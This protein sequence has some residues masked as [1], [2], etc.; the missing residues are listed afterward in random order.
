MIRRFIFLL[1]VLGNFTVMPISS[2]GNITTT[3]DYATMRKQAARNKVE[4][5]YKDALVVF[6]ALIAS[7]KDDLAADDY[8]NAI[9]CY[10]NLNLQN[11]TDAFTEDII[12]IYS[13]NTALLIA[14]AEYYYQ[15]PHYGYI[16]SGKFRRGYHRGGG[17]YV[18]SLERDRVR[19][20]QL[21]E[22]A[23]S[24]AA[25]SGEKLSLDFYNLF[26][27]VILLQHNY[28][29]AWR[30]QY[31]TDTSALPD[32]S[33]GYNSGYN[34]NRAP[35]DENGNPVFYHIPKSY[36]AAANDGE[37]WR[38]MMDEAITAYPVSKN[39]IMQNYADFLYNQFGVQTMQEYSWFFARDFIEPPSPGNDLS[40]NV[41][42]ATYALHTLKDDETMAKLASGIKRFPLPDDCNYLKIYKELNVH[43]QLAQIYENR[44]QYNK[45]VNEWKKD[46]NNDRIKQITG[47]WGRFEST[48]TFAAGKN[49]VLQFRFRNGDEV[50]LT[51][52]KILIKPLLADIKEYIKSNPRKPEWYKLQI[53]NI[54]YRLV[55]KN[56]KKYLGDTV[57]EWKEKLRPADMHFDKRIDIKT[58]LKNAGAY[59][60]TARMKDGNIS[61]IVLW[62]NDTIIIRKNLDDQAYFYVADALTGRP[63]QNI[64][65]DFF[66]YKRNYVSGKFRDYNFETKEFELDT[67]NNGQC[68]VSSLK[69]NRSLQWLITAQNQQGRLAYMGFSGIWYQR[70]REQEYNRTKAFMIT[71]R[72]VYRP[73][74]IV[75]FK[76]WIRHTRYNQPDTSDFANKE[77]GIIITNP[78]GDKVFNKTFTTDK[79]G[80]LN[81]EFTLPE[82]AVLGIYRVAI[83]YQG[84]SLN[85]GSFRVEEYKKP[86][87]EVKI[88]APDKPVMLGDKIAATVRAKYYFGAPVV[89][90]KVKYKVLRYSYNKNW[91]PIDEWDWLYGVGYWW[92][93][94]DYN[95]YP[96]WRKWGCMPPR[97]WWLPVPHT[98]P[99]VIADSTLKLDKDGEG[100]ITI[101][102]A[103]TK[104]MHG[105]TDHRYEI[106]VEVT[107]ESRRT[108]VGKGNV[109]VARKPFKV[110]VWLDRGY[111]NVGDTIH[112]S[113]FAQ[114]LDNKPVKGHGVL[115]LYKIKY[116]KD[117]TPR[118]STVQQWQL[119]TD[120]QG[121]AKVQ[122]NAMIAGQYRFSY[123]LTDNNHHTIEGG[124]IFC[125]RGQG[126]SGKDFHF[127]NLEITQDHRTYKPGDKANIMIST[128]QKNSTVLLF[129]RPENGVY[130][131]PDIMHIKGK[132]ST[133]AI[134]ITGKDMPNI[135][136]EALTISN[137]KVYTAVREISVPPEKRVLNVQVLSPKK[138]YKP[139]EKA[140][141]TLR[142]TDIFGNPFVGSAVLTVYD[143][144]LEYISGGS[145]VGNIKEFFWKW[146][147]THTPVT[148]TSNNKQSYNLVLPKKQPMNNLGVFGYLIADQFDKEDSAASISSVKRKKGMLRAMGGAA[149]RME[150][151]VAD[152]VSPVMM[153]GIANKKEQPDNKLQ[154]EPESSTTAV[155]LMR[156]KF[157]DTAYW[158]AN[159]L[160]DS[161]GLAII[162]FPMPDNLTG[163]QIK[164]WAMGSGTK[165]GEG[166]TEIVTTKKLLLRMQSPRFFVETDEVVL[167]ANIHNYL[168]TD[169]EVT[170][171]LKLSGNC[172]AIIPTNDVIMVS[173]TNADKVITI[174]A[175]GEK[176]VDWRVKVLHEGDVK[177]QMQALTDEESDAMEM[178]FPVYVHGILKTESFSG[179]VR[180][181][182]TKAKIKFSV[183]ENR[184]INDSRLEVRYS[185]SLAA[186]MV[187]AL[188]YL[189]EY[190]YGCTEQTLNR[191]LPAVITRKVLMNMGINLAAI[192]EKRTNL[193]AQEI[194]NDI[195]R[196]K[197]W[198]RWKH[199]PVFD[200]QELDK[201]LRA[202]VDR[203]ANMQLSDGGWGWFS[204]W[205]EH[206]S[207][208]TTALVV[209][210]LQIARKYGV[211]VNERLINNG[212][213]W[214]KKYQEKQ[215]RLIKNAKVDKEP[216]KEYADNLDAFV[217]MVLADSDIHNLDMDNFLYRDRT[218][219]AVY[220]KAMYGLALQK[221]NQPAKRDMLIR[222]IEQY[223]VR[224]KENQTA[225]LNL[226]NGGYWW[227]WYGSEYEAQAYY[228]K[229]L[230]ATD[231][232]N[233]DAAGLAKYLINNRKHATYWNSTRDTAI[234]IEALADYIQASGENKPDMTVAVYLDGKKRKEVHITEENL[235][236]FDNKFVLTG[237]NIT[238]GKHKLEIKKKGK[239]SVY[240]NT[241]LT[242]FSLEDF[243][244]KAGLEIKVNRKYYK[245]TKIDKTIKT[246]GS[247]GQVLNQKVEK[248]KRTLIQDPGK[249]KSG[250]L[251]EVEL[252]IE[253]KNDY[254]YVIFEDMKPA[255]FEPVAVRSGYN[256]NELGA[257]M[258]LRDRKICLF[259]KNLAR[260]KHSVSYR[261][262][263]EIP[264]RFS[265]LPTKAYAMYAPELKANSDEM[266]IIIQDN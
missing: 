157:A 112:A 254:E 165:V 220:A 171:V 130:R 14:A 101:D 98:P 159:I 67:D 86:E 52:Q 42:T 103:I 196:A 226:Q 133:T 100:K 37:R 158:D 118:E 146:R 15:A 65:L 247:H 31:L 2:F 161:N 142:I 104:A 57:A 195:E 209:H 47:N 44:R 228:L 66:G 250:D 212:I 8:K 178:Q 197:Q 30:L 182:K 190:P 50:E 135:F 255:G 26:I 91:Y 194:G 80:G 221:Q 131:L 263:A 202:G 235:F 233:P 51:A 113:L 177:I 105:D 184:R 215:V 199:N 264:G 181:D 110:Y 71:D 207:A 7:G 175:G 76:Y 227:Y 129:V 114:T 242:Y 217:Y 231:P 53:N 56:E 154:E 83:W 94:G 147:R 68:I 186:A 59:L 58:P 84:R 70:W 192:K 34:I 153:S 29:E 36:N 136:V 249:L 173:A 92:F 38:W 164:S 13:N 246:T 243:I 124:Y 149:P 35:V 206:S 257:Y 46:G 187:D 185:P 21:L 19:S 179:V 24:L 32:Y 148:T 28:R 81:G 128:E 238:G 204:G 1:V 167:S 140:E 236:T 43:Q 162:E 10:Q 155:P 176:R 93:A 251:V 72:P 62:I 241:Y 137:G 16:I 41:Q 183:P 17:K 25:Q 6:R 5:N 116:D 63:V 121:K 252:E 218:R 126:F 78:K 240:F 134:D 96:G 90:A 20:L 107:D 60:V 198:K 61:K 152:E 191:F 219:L 222:N 73:T 216:C 119:D 160:T 180:P 214:L 127:N 82:N 45:A 266:K 55:T 117:G 18:R 39:S 85:S 234:C 188:P 115:N 123:K 239:G 258:E 223:I 109:L 3:E 11:E 9:S 89:N 102:T 201:M 213:M 143:R 79:Y 174:P 132:N 75:K 262:R 150:K 260:G 229:L 225:Y 139:R 64:T 87:F 108:I 248:Y 95:W 125:I 77:F 97:A 168:K 144:A 205:Q 169:K 244:K 193:N 141:I 27:N 120:A 54:G 69:Y 99:E 200:K 33:Y 237:R 230:A 261:M 88:D 22:Q 170:A 12:S 49:A 151:M 40:N 224:D 189:A 203:L 4:G 145:N 163:W 259:V 211:G 166:S 122:I 253:S 156:N 208:H 256:G 111:Y 74:Q 232:H 172:L 210:G 245:L 48:G 138:E 106:T 265:A 23:Q